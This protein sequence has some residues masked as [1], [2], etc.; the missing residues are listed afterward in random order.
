[1][2]SFKVSSYKSISIEDHVYDSFIDWLEHECDG[3]Q[4]TEALLNE[5]FYLE[6]T[7]RVS[8]INVLGG[9]RNAKRNLSR[10]N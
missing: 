1:M 10:K 4:P 8:L 6:R 9:N 5:F 3:A 7:H 2:K